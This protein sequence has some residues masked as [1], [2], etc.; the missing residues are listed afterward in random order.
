MAQQPK[1]KADGQQ[2]QRR[3]TLTFEQ[4]AGVN[5][6][7][8]RAGVPDEQAY[9]LDGFMPLSQRNLRTL[10]DAGPAI[11]GRP[12]NE[13]GSFGSITPGSGGSGGPYLGQSLLGGSGSGAIGNI[14]MQS[15]SVSSV[16]LVSGGGGYAVNN[17]LSV[18]GV[19]GLTG[20]SV[21]VGSVLTPTLICFG[22]YNIGPTPYA[23][24]F[25]SDGSAIQIN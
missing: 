16:G 9:W 24:V 3:D 14:Y 10:W 2:Q 6:A 21:L 12:I 25:L 5:T 8:T 18:S 17:S 4:F 11:Y 20:F 23:V 1:Q 15:G 13:I 22:F 7:T 19:T